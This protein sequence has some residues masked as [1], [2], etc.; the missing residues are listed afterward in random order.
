[1]ALRG[2]AFLRRNAIGLLALVVALSG[3]AYAANTIGARDIKRNAIRSPH[4]KT[5]QVK[6]SDLAR[7][8]RRKIYAGNSAGPVNTPDPA[9]QLQIRRV[10]SGTLI[11]LPEEVD[12]IEAVCPP[13]Y[14][15]VGTGFYAGIADVGFVLSYGSFVGGAFVNETGIVLEP[16]VEAICA[17]NSQGGATSSSAAA[18]RRFQRQVSE[19]RAALG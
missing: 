9:D 17:R 1:M 6:K 5:G 16:T 2:L 8:L 13:G 18:H 14:A 3:T 19:L 7:Y 10:T 15:V 11:L 4:I 12:A